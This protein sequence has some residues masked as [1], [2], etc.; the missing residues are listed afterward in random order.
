MVR[1]LGGVD[2][3]TRDGTSVAFERGKSLELTVWLAHH[4]E[5]ATRSAARAALWEHEVR[6]A[7]FANIVS[8]ARRS[9]GRALPPPHDEEWIGRTL[10]DQLPLHP[11]VC[12]DA[13]ML[14]ARLA[15]SA[16]LAPAEAIEVLRPGVALVREQPF[17]GTDHLWPA[18]EGLASALTLLVTSATTELA[19]HHLALGDIDGVFWATG[20]GLKVLS[21]QEDLIGL[22]M[23]AHHQ[24]GDIAGVRREWETYERAITA[25]S[26]SDG[27]PSPKLLTLRR[28]LLNR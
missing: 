2:I 19:S 21:G 27:E 9:L 12:T 1:V 23:R 22:R 6:D 24:R 25:E 15:A 5:H 8:D 26:W 28:E 10:T 4:R 17:A 16:G 14:Q 7:T 11:L 20:Q 3:V 18:T 13:E